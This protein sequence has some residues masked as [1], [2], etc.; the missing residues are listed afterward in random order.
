MPAVRHVYPNAEQ[1]Y[2]GLAHVDEYRWYTMIL[3]SAVACGSS[4]SASLIHAHLSRRYCLA[5]FLLQG[6]VDS[7]QYEQRLTERCS[8]SRSTA[9]PKSSPANGKTASTSQSRRPPS[10]SLPL[11]ASPMRSMLNDKRGPIGKL[12]QGIRPEHRE[13]WFIFAQFSRASHSH[14][15]LPYRLIGLQSTAASSCFLLR[16]CSSTVRLP[17]RPFLSSYSPSPLGTGPHSTS[18]S[19]V[20]SALFIPKAVPTTDV[21]A[22]GSSGNWSDCERRWSSLRLLGHPQ[23]RPPQRLPAPPARCSLRQT[24]ITAPMGIR[25]MDWLTRPLSCP[26]LGRSQRTLYRNS[27]WTR[28][29]SS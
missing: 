19:S 23:L 25:R 22:P 14:L 4:P 16:H 20:E 3:M 1:R 6:V 18:R 8:L 10:A 26:G 15:S 29:R 7:A 21:F 17:A 27:C 2:P 28:L 9:G 13:L 11:I 5:S 12:L 24:D